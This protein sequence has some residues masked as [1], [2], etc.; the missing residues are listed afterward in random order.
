[1]KDS[2]TAKKRD[3]LYSDENVKYTVTNNGVTTFKF[4]FT[5]AIFSNNK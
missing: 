1:M 2:K 5:L 3:F 4:L